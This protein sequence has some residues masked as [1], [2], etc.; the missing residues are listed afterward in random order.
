MSFVL[1]LQ[2]LRRK[3][4]QSY[5]FW[6]FF[7]CC[8]SRFSCSNSFAND[9]VDML[10]LLLIFVWYR[11][12]FIETLMLWWYITKR[13]GMIVVVLKSGNKLAQETAR[14][15]KENRQIWTR[16]V[17]G[18]TIIKKK[19]KKEKHK[20]CKKCTTCCKFNCITELLMWLC[21]LASDLLWHHRLASESL[22]CGWPW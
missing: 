5:L 2:S 20:R 8:C 3:A 16:S 1:Y 9:Q 6:I 21:S 12:S 19:K 17:L 15:F 10:L 18:I 13:P 11:H 4:C 22:G 14:L 7:C